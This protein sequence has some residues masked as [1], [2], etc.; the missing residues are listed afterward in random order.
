MKKI[1]SLVLISTTLL[2]TVIASADIQT[3]SIDEMWGKPTLV[4]GGGLTD[5]Q[6]Q[7]VNDTFAIKNLDNVNRLQATG[8]DMDTYLRS[9]GAQTS[10]MLS[11][12]LVQKRNSSAGVHVNI[13]TP[14]NITLIS[15]EQYTNAAIT[16]G[17]TGL[18]IEVASP[19]KVT[20]KSA[21]TGVYVALKGNGEKVDTQR[22][23]VAQD[24]LSTVGAISQANDLN[25]NEKAQLS[26]TLSQIKSDLAKYKQDNQAPADT[27]EIRKIVDQ[28][29]K[30]NNLSNVITPENI[31]S[32]VVLSEAYQKTSAVD[33]ADVQKALG[34]LQSQMADKFNNIKDKLP[35]VDTS[36][37]D[38]IGQWLR[39]FWSY[40]VSMWPNL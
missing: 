2:P 12:V 8:S 31:E 21:L 14:E 38:T 15:E 18:D 23:Q 36:L 37:L 17:A 20:G 13:K 25:K 32:L 9:S 40:L 29:I 5:I 22:T 19:S 10:A 34:D 35:N 27:T 6:V 16:A 4:Y 11:S 30:D 26:S 3:D 28:A 1:L 33:D 24:E 7:A 39:D